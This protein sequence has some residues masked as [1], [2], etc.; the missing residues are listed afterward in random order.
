MKPKTEIKTF[1]KLS[2]ALKAANG[3]PI[4]S[5]RSG[6]TE[7]F[8]VIQADDITT[9]KLAEVT[10]L[11]NGKNGESGSAGHVCLNHLDRLGN[12]DWA[13][14]GRPTGYYAFEDTERAK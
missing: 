14:T 4:I 2:S 9:L 1:R 13:T 5:V 8:I 12:A 11:A 10:L 7:I 3:L 6:A